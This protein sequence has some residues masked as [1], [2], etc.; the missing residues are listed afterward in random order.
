MLKLYNT[1]SRKIED[2]VP[3][4]PSKVG[5]YTCGPTVYNYAHIGNLR[6]YIFEDILRRVLQTNGYEVNHVMNITDVGHLTSDADSGE[7]KMEAGATREQK[8]VWDIAS[9]Y[10]KAFFQDLADLNILE[11]RV[12]CKATDHIKEQTNLILQLQ[13]RGLTYQTSDGIY[14]D[15]SKLSDYGKLAKLDL[16]GLEA[17]NRVE[18]GEK[19]HVTDF[20]L[21]KFSP[22]DSKR[23]MEWNSPWGVGFPGWHIECSAMSLKYL[24]DHFDIHC[25]GI[26]HIPVHHTNE[27]AQNE[28]ALGHQ[29]VNYWLHGEFLLTNDERMGKSKGNFF[30]LP[31][32]KEKDFDPLAYRY[33]CLSAH[34][35]AKL[36]FSFEALTGAANAL[37]KLHQ[38]VKK[39]ARET[40][41]ATEV[42]TVIL[43]RFRQAANEDLNMPQALAVMW[44]V[45]HAN[46]MPAEIKLATLLEIDAVLGLHLEAVLADANS[47]QADIPPEVMELV[48]ARE[49]AR[50]AK[51]WAESD[52]LRAE[53]TARGYKVEDTPTGPAVMPL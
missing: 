35:R 38:A 52:K 9:F 49:T 22:A 13:E 45:V 15:T 10:T 33:F 19:K 34:Y 26:D 1:L 42:D 40:T 41:A 32:V 36:N 4:T 28:G 2:F 25:G 24:G 3:I 18:M 12:I 21:W 20:A 6:T 51:M 17:G 43:E 8:T 30:T 53:I 44:E 11:P 37:Q 16:A 29:T 39:L 7:D 48:T 31:V 50:Q 27:I 23:Q 14:F 46:D 47:A 5:L